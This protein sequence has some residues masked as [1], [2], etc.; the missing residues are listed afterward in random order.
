MEE[1]YVTLAET[2]LGG[3]TGDLLLGSSNPSIGSRSLG[4]RLA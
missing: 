3:P 4:L 2:W 1:Y